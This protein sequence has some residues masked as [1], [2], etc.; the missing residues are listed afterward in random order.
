MH[1]FIRQVYAYSAI[2]V[3][4][5]VS[6]TQAAI[7][8]S[9][10]FDYSVCKA[11]HIVLATEGQSI[12]GRMEV[13]ES[14]KGD[15]S[16]GSTMLLPELAE[17][18]EKK[19][20]RVHW[21]S[22]KE[23]PEP[24]VRFVTGSRMILFLV[25]NSP[26]Q[27]S[28]KPVVNNKTWQPAAQYGGFKVSVVW[29]EN[30][31]AYA[32]R[33]TGNPGPSRLEYFGTAIRMKARIAAYVTILADLEAAIKETN[34]VR[35]AQTFSAFL[36]SD[37]NQ[38]ARASL[39]AIGNMGECSLPILRRLLSDVT[40]RHLHDR[41]IATMVRAGGSNII[42][43]LLKIVNEEL[44]YWS[45]QA[46][47]L[48]VGWWNADPANQR[49][50]LREHYSKLLEALRQLQVIGCNEECKSVVTDTL[51]LWKTTPALHDI[52]DGQMARTCA[53]LLEK[54]SS[55]RQTGR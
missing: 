15:I 3:I 11:T 18:A 27:R 30:G 44:D 46:P 28:D 52:G 1:Y 41:I 36:D 4:L 21:W 6:S 49:K 22:L 23:L 26:Q 51:E 20:C 47:E 2:I 32:Y 9:F 14:W 8:P 16:P 40:L 29:I 25:K 55:D 53:A 12:D 37:F 50:L 13:L 42:S 34:P 43:D 7:R 54:V 45:G 5:S 39:D 19:Q 17:F 31:E 10:I 48:T 33:Q 38:G 24:Y 35:A